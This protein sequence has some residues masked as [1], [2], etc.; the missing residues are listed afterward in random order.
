M[1]KQDPGCP[2]SPTWLAELASGPGFNSSFVAQMASTAIPRA[3]RSTERLNDRQRE[4]ARA[5]GAQA[6][7]S[8]EPKV[9]SL[10]VIC[11]SDQ[12]NFQATNPKKI[13]FFM[14]LPSSDSLYRC[15]TENLYPEVQRN[16]HLTATHQSAETRGIFLPDACVPV[17]TATHTL[18][19]THSSLIPSL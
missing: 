16:R 8:L 10:H 4:R 15:P 7:S 2:T 17:C 5:R 13:T 3:P 1:Q 19:R 9:P 12:H 6:S 18:T 11:R 14:S